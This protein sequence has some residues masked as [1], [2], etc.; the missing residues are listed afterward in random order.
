MA[1]KIIS[2]PRKNDEF[3]VA[4]SNPTVLKS[5]ILEGRRS[6]LQSMK[7]LQSIKEIRRHKSDERQKLRR[8]I[9]HIYLVLSKL[10]TVMPKVDIPKEPKPVQVQAKPIE[11]KKPAKHT[12]L[13]E[14]E[15]IEMELN[16]IDSQL[17]SLGVDQ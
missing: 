11:E 3:F 5:S 1:K 2:K 4:V 13:S 17:K 9:K 14:I 10:K 15:K 16:N 7:L 12:S 8:Q 6:L